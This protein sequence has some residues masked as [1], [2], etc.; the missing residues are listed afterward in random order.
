MFGMLFAIDAV[1]LDGEL[2]VLAIR[3]D[4]RPWRA[5]VFGERTKCVLELPGGKSLRLGMTVGD[6]LTMEQ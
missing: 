5:A 4:L 3:R 6:V 1:A 2:R